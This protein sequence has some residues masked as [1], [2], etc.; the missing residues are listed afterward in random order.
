MG[1]KRDTGLF[2][3]IY[4]AVT[5]TGT[6][7]KHGRDFWERP[8]QTEHNY[9]TGPQKRFPVRASSAIAIPPNITIP[10]VN[11][12]NAGGAAIS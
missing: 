11:T 3:R 1:K 2:E 4:N 8:T 7:V 5:G 6:N 12:L 9:D 10:V